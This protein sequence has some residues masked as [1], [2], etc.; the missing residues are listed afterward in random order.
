[1]VRIIEI[2]HTG[3]LC[4]TLYTVTVSFFGNP[5][6]LIHPPHSLLVTV[7]FGGISTAIGAF[8][9]KIVGR[10]WLR[11]LHPVQGFLAL[12]VWRLV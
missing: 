10:N 1:M 6:T 12:R 2:A 3:T 8:L 5:T 4:H 9:L 11:V 7:T